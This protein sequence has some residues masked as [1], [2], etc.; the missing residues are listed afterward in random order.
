MYFLDALSKLRLHESIGTRMLGFLC[1]F[2]I[3]ATH[4]AYLI[5]KI[6]ALTS[7]KCKY[8]ITRVTILVFVDV[9]ENSIMVDDA[10]MP[11]NPLVAPIRG[12][13]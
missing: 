13:A 4:Y 1:S 8:Q 11:L 10:T 3:T 9:S 5:L 2:V 6:K 7:F 12:R